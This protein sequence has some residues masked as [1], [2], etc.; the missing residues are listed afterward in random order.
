VTMAVSSWSVTHRLFLHADR[1]WLVTGTVTGI[2]DIA[3]LPPIDEVGS[4]VPIHTRRKLPIGCHTALNR[5]ARLGF[6]SLGF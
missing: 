1:A 5:S 6:C 4:G 2:D 3:A